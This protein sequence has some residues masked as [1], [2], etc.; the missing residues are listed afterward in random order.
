MV[1]DIQNEEI[2]Q[3]AWTPVLVASTANEPSRVTPV[4]AEKVG[5]HNPLVK[6]GTLKSVMG[7]TTPFV[8]KGR[9]YRLENWQKFMEIPRATVAERYL[10]DAVRIWDVEADKLVSV[11]LVGHSFGMA[12]VWNDRVHVYSAAHPAGKEWR[13]VTEITLTT[14][15]DLIHWSKPE[16]VLTAEPGEHLFNVA[17]CRGKDRFIMLYETNDKRWPP[18]TFKYCESDDLRHWKLIPEVVYGREK[19]VGG[20]ALYYEGDWYY[21]LYLQNRSGKF[22]TRITR[23]RDLLHWEDAPVDRPFLTFDETRPYEYWHHGELRKVHE[24]NAS[25]AELCEWQGKTLVYF[26]GGDQESAGD[27]Q[28]AVFDGPPRKLFEAFFAEP[29]MITPSP[30]QLAYQELQFGTFVH[31]G[32]ATF[33]GNSDMLVTPD[34]KIFNPAELDAAQWVL[35]AKA[36]GAR[37]LVLTAKHHSGFCLWPTA[38]TKYSV[39]SSPWRGGKGDVVR[40]VANACRKHG[41]ALGLYYSLG[42][43][44]AGCWATPQPMG[45]RVLVGYRS[46]FLPL[47]KA[48]LREILTGYGELAVVWFDGAYDPFGWDVRS[49]EHGWV[50]GTAEGNEVAGLVRSLQPKAAIFGSTR[51][52]G[53]WAGNEDGWAPYPL[54]NV[55]P[56]GQGL[57]H[58]VS[59]E[60]ENK[61]LYPDALLFTRANWF[62][63]PNS[64]HTL[65]SAEEL[66]V[67]YCRSVGRGA[68]ALFNLT[69]DVHGRLSETEVARVGEF[70]ELVRKRLGTSIAETSSDGRWDEGMALNLAWDAPKSVGYIILEEDLRYGQRIRK[71]GVEAFVEGV[72]KTVAMG[73]TIGRQ[74]I[75]VLVKPV[76]TRQLRVRIQDSAPMPKL[77]R[78]AAMVGEK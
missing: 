42:D 3:T 35:A 58:W 50:L 9:L 70:G 16:T 21:T 62:W 25:D 1:Q 45:E 51:P 61:W 7:E 41:L 64:D 11:A 6:Q 46:T 77:R 38:T 12:F 73:A 65:L 27:L 60:L 40:E 28:A 76:M 20:P 48:Q 68:T 13:T 15:D 30:V 14:S 24:I 36:M 29:S 4:M 5:W 72:W 69:P 74:R 43:M 53:R 32:T 49:G 34:P 8:F 71:Y 75:E 19:Y 44:Q 78:F 39:E 52:D 18:F 10:E 26:N 54:G 63:T 22:E 31:F 67:R 56:P 47:V 33:T 2:R 57:A 23:S 55:V 59:P 66:F 37:V 17:I